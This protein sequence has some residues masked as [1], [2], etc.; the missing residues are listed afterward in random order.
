MANA[1]QEQLQQPD[2][3]TL[4]VEERLGLLLDRE[5]TEREN[6]RLKTR[7]KQAKLRPSA[8]IE[9]IDDRAPRGLDKVLRQLPENNAPVSRG[10][11]L[12]HH[13]VLG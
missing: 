13:M 8:A 11:R 3:A 5:A 4:R 6:R 2:I 9:D 10:C 1:L 7:L 12:N